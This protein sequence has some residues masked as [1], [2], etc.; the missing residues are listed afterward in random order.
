MGLNPPLLLT[1]AQLVPDS[2]ARRQVKRLGSLRSEPAAID[3]RYQAFRERRRCAH[4][5]ALRYL[6][7]SL[8]IARQIEWIEPSLGTT[9][10][11]EKMHGSQHRAADAETPPHLLAIATADDTSLLPAERG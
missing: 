9:A 4:K 6:L 3:Y 8:G 5:L 11:P 7:Q 2:P 10:K 1:S